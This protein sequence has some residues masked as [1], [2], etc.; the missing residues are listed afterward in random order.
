MKMFAPVNIVNDIVADFS[1]GRGVS[2]GFWVAKGFK[3]F[4]LGS[5]LYRQQQVYSNS[6]NWL[7]I[8]S[9]H[10]VD[11]FIGEGSLRWYLQLYSITIRINRIHDELFLLK[12]E[13]SELGEAIKGNYPYQSDYEWSTESA[14]DPVKVNEWNLFKNKMR[15]RFS[16]IW[17]CVK[18]VLFR[19]FEVTSRF[20][21]A[22]DAFYMKNNPLIVLEGVEGLQK[23]VEHK[24]D[25]IDKL[26]ENKKIID[27]LI[28]YLNLSFTSND[29]IKTITTGLNG[30]GS[31]NDGLN[32]LS[33]NAGE[34]LKKVG[35]EIIYQPLALI[36]VTRI[37]PPQLCPSQKKSR[38]KFGK[39]VTIR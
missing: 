9:G 27:Q 6:D 8:L 38:V 7:Y 21:D 10:V 20:L 16:R 22:Y 18:N 11:K 24:E 13:L 26:T 34:L 30:V 12:E 29:V 37:L 36:N 32:T 4:H 2:I 15:D 28:R 14:E 31:V 19:T 35:K 23:I 33:H 25:I 39:R 5:W 1:P 17:L 3:V